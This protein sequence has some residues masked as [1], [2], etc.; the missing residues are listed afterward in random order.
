MRIEL[1]DD[2]IE[3][4]RLVRP[5]DRRGRARVP[6]LT[7]LPQD[8]LRHPARDAAAGGRPD[9][10][11]TARCA[12]KF[13]KD[14]DKL[15]E[16][17][18]L[19]QRTRFDMEMIREL[20]YCNGIENYSRY[21]SGPGAGRAAADLFDYLPAGCPGDCRRVARLGP[22]DWRHVRATARAR[23]RWWS[24]AFGCPRPWT[25]AR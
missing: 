16:A 15:V 2:E 17:Q 25:T 8:P 22:A 5:A 13:L 1:F 3:Q 20:G 7:I 11:R 14:K 10:G 6:R 24:T 19:V 12:S 21:L 18:R 23:R 9:R 4:H